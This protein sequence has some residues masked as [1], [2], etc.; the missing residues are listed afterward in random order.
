MKNL[1]LIFLLI[2]SFNLNL[3]AKKLDDDSKM[4][5]YVG[6]IFDAGCSSSFSCSYD[7]ICIYE[8]I[9]P[10][11]L[12]NEKYKEIYYGQKEIIISLKSKIEAYLAGPISCEN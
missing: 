1:F 6:K 8:D 2:F 4:E 7:V 11:K 3:S 10:S 5:I 12:T 9:N